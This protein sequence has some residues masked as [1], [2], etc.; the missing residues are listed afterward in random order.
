[1]PKPRF[2]VA[3]MGRA[4]SA[5]GKTRLLRSLGTADGAGLRRALLR[6]TLDVVGR[7]QVAS[8]VVV[9]TPA[10][11]E[12][13]V[14]ALVPAGTRL[15]PQRGTD[16]GERLHN[17]FVDLL[18]GGADA[19][20]IIGS[21]LPTLPSRHVELGI[22]VLEQQIGNLVL[23]PS[24]DGGYY[25]I[26]LTRPEPRLFEDIPW[27]TSGVFERTLERARSLALRVELLPEWYDVDSVGDLEP[28]T[29]DDTGDPDRAAAH[30]RAWLLA[31]PPEVRAK[32]IGQTGFGPR[33][34][35]R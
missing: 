18:Q 32:V 17:A 34:A 15:L 20:L 35:C 21:D 12:S 11:A 7:V 33:I 16:L 25:L 29:R 31:A 6:D 13:E 28:L 27:G 9:Y 14:Y 26:G 4:P 23:G 19:A 10:D 24:P 5:E 30:T 2:V 3:I 22:E 8:K 1:M